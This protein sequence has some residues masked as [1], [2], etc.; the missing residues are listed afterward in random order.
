M[1]NDTIEGVLDQIHTAILAGDFSALGPMALALERGLT[2]LTATNPALL[3][4]ISRKSARNAACLKAAGDGVRAARRRLA[5]L[6][7]IAAGLVTY[8]GQG[9]RPAF[10]KPGHMTRR[11]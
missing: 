4:R 8:D 7:Q 5:E 6:R 11:L 10:D 1:Q 9:K 3:Q 2:N